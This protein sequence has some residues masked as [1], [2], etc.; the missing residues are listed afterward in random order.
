MPVS[1]RPVRA[2]I[3]VTG[4][5]VLTGRISD[6]NGP[7][8]AE[9]LGE[10]GV[11]VSH[12]VCVG[13][14]APDLR[15]A[16][17]FLADVGVELIVTSGGLGPTADDLTAEVVGEFAGRELVL[18]EAMEERIAEILAGFARRFRFDAEAL[19][20]ANRKQALVP[21]GATAIDPAG[22]APGL[23]VPTDG[24]TVIVLPGPPRELK[25]MWPEALATDAAR[26]AMAKVTPIHTDTLRIFGI[27]ESELAKSLREIEG[28][29]DLAPLE[30]T[31]C[32]R[33]AELEID[34]RY[35]DGAEGVAKGLLD[36]LADRFER[37]VFSR[38]GSTIDQQ[39]A[40]LLADRRIGIAESET[41]GL[42]AA[43]LTE[44]PGS[45]AY[46]AGGVVAY[47][48]EAKRELLDVPEELLERHGAVSPEV[49]EA[50]ADGALARFHADVGVAITGIA[51]PGG[52]TDEKP[53][54]YVCI[55]VKLASGEIVAR[56]PV[57]P[58]DRAEIR[59]RSTTVAMHLV[60]RL[61][62]GE[63]F[64]L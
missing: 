16:L 54:G 50:M 1:Q 53:V 27:P 24:P 56:D 29:L 41:A 14:R 60:R 30:I 51:G 40:S 8:L 20:E 42:L 12:I 15:A 48:N 28:D 26:S 6:R 5:E 32:L 21:E 38:D 43:R 37:Y 46:M 31:T 13:D 19:R 2:G 22:T 7:W 47:S 63:D 17:G 52:G 57:L 55:C 23:V 58:G 3:V 11:E 62:R 44:I 45:S 4:T 10:L 61:L 64:P 33:R 25:A 36:E 39:I 18:D 59:D 35:R 9:R 49:A 34:V